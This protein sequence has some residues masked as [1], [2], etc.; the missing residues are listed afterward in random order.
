M[1]VNEKKSKSMLV[2]SKQKI[3]KKDHTSLNICLNDECI[4]NVDCYKLLGLQV[5]KHL[6]WEKQVAD[7][8]KKVAV[9]LGILRNIKH[10]LPMYV[11]K[12]FVNAYVLP[13]I[14]YC[15]TIW[16]NCRKDL[17]SKVKRLHKLAAYLILNTSGRHS[18]KTLVSML[19]WMTLDERIHFKKAV[20]VYK[21]LHGIDR[22]SVV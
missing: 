6:T 14:D 20:L 21:S 19:N 1:L 8:C 2:S 9:K 11:R 18:Y 5:D 16:G 17:V 15:C 7:V 4:D 12:L 13:L 22:K 3:R 10:Y